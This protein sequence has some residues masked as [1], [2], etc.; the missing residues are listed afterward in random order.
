MKAYV[1][2]R[3][4]R[5][6]YL[7]E[8]A[9]DWPTVFDAISA[10]AFARWG[11]RST[12]IVP[13]EN[14]AIRLA[15]IPWPKAYDADIIYSYV[16]LSDTAVEQ[17]HEQ[18]GPAFL[19]RHDFHHRSDRDQFAYRPDLPIQPLSVLSVMAVMT[20]GNMISAP[21]LSRWSTRISAH[22]LRL[23]CNRIS[24]ATGKA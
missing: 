14:G 15:Y 13:C 18:F 1:R 24:V 3:P 16:D 22:G 2:P 6:A 20:R 5:V 11:G 9:D 10:E 19:I 8:E 21:R 17:I 4:I 12:F 23:S 7:I